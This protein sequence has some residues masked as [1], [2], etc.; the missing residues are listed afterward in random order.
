MKKNK[1]TIFKPAK[2]AMQ[3]GISNT[4]KWCLVSNEIDETFIN[5]KFC[6]IGSSN[7]EKK[8][9]LEFKNLEDA[10]RFAKKNNYNY[11]VIKPKK[12]KLIK[13]SYA[14]NFVKRKN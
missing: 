11:E 9:L 2:S 6:W 7:P 10:E 4:K 14:Q 3:S 5:I 13:K 12:R 8:V 1:F